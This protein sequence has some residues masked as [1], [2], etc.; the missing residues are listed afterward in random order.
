MGWRQCCKLATRWC[1]VSCG[2][3]VFMSIYRSFWLKHNGA[4]TPSQLCL[5]FALAQQ[6]EHKL[7]SC[8]SSPK[9]QNNPQYSRFLFCYYKWHFVWP[10]FRVSSV[11]EQRTA[12]KKKSL[13]KQC[14]N[15]KCLRN[16]P[17]SSISERGDD[18]WQLVCSH[19]PSAEEK[20]RGNEEFQSKMG[21]RQLGEHDRIMWEF[22]RKD[23][24][25]A[26]GCFNASYWWMQQLLHIRIILECLVSPV[27]HICCDCTS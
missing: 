19:L 26:K 18:W 11:S 9:T 16:E 25:K 27:P 12:V 23:L 6:S 13:G 15:S 14:P 24:W 2:V 17:Q 8:F 5:C 1:W 10:V 3:S 20:L 4:L 7:A 21:L 22:T